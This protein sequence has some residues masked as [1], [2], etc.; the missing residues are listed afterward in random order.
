MSSPA[1]E[2]F[3]ARLYSDPTLAESFCADMS[4][5]VQGAGLSDEEIAALREIDQTGL[6]MA[7][8][9]YAHKRAGRKPGKSH[10]GLFGWLRK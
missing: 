7:A 9:S 6:K 3:L 10:G 5:A 4:S 1:L 8:A 2:A